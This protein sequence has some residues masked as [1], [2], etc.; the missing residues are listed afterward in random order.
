[1]PARNA[2]RFIGAAIDSVLRQEG[3]ELELIVVDDCSDDGTADV[4]ESIRDRRLRLLRN[5]QRRGIGACHNLV[6]R[7]SRAPYIAHVDADDLILPGA[8]RKLVD[9]VAGDPR[10]GQSHC[11]F[12]DIDRDGN[13]TRGSFRRRWH[14]LRQRRPPGLDYRRALL[15]ENVT[16]A[17]RTYRR[18]ALDAAGA[19]D[20]R[21]PFAV[22][23]D[24]ALRIVDR[25]RIALAPEFL[26]AR[27][28]HSRNTT[29]GLRFQALRFKA[30]TYLIRRRLIGSGRIRFI[31]GPRLDLIGFLRS[32]WRH[33]AR[34]VRAVVERGMRRSTTLVRWRLW[35]PIAAQLY[36]QANLRLGWWPLVW[37]TTSRPQAPTTPRVIYYARVFPALSETFIQRE[38]ATLWEMGAPLDVVAEEPNGS[39]HFGDEA[40]RLSQCTV[41][42]GRPTAT[43]WSTL[44]RLFVRQPLATINIFLYVLCRT[45]SAPKTRARDR[46][47]WWRA[48][49]L[50]TTARARG[51]TRIHAPWATVDALV[52]L[53]AARLAGIDYSVQARASDLYK[54][55]SHVGLAERLGHADFVITNAHYNL[56]AIR[57]Q[58]TAARA[59]GVH[60]IY[61]GVDLRRLV[62]ARGCERH[63]GPPLLLS[64]ARLVE[65]KGI[66]V[67]LRACR[68]LKDRGVAFRCEIIGARDRSE[69]R[70]YLAVKRAWHDLGLQDDVHFLGAC[71][72]DLV[73]EKYAQAAVCVLAAQPVAD[74][75]RDVTPNTIIEAMAMGVPVVSSRS[76]AID[77][78]VEDGVTG[79][80]VP[81]RDES[82]LAAAIARLLG[83]AELRRAMGSAARRRAEERFDIR[84]NAAGYAAL[85]G[86][87]TPPGAPL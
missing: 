50:A 87:G 48:V 26:Y 70:Y 12:F 34:R 9:A 24:M 33:S 39:A 62:P 37:H 38:V 22:D 17:L 74:G 30:I 60:T 72:F 32:R 11:Y 82:A 69:T 3:I 6:L 5:P 77:E 29:E 10:A 78:L 61:E 63:G 49:R 58:L 84:M 44:A 67:L 28:L 19:F 18:S 27:R 36:R 73:R 31:S 35:A 65:P 71:V 79:L 20:E 25:D 1:M 7:Y 8:L 51:A 53:L 55:V 52:A 41:Y 64:V 76:G 23:Y 15:V 75:R 81:P 80:L 45:H 43:S 16:N 57:A 83:D 46:S 14:L 68:L 86:F 59:P 40:A 66:D 4:V 85:F 54:D 21:L 56:P 13:A 42:L 47:L 2:A